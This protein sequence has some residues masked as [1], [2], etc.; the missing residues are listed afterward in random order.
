MSEARLKQTANSVYWIASLNR[1]DITLAYY[2][3]DFEPDFYP[4]GSREYNLAWE[5][6]MKIP[7]IKNVT[8]TSWNKNKVMSNMG[9]DCQ[10]IGPSVDIDL[11]RPR[12]RS[13]FIL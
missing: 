10:I 7:R 4:K 11:F 9:I 3:Q 1:S 2:I 12:E 6:Y 8:K 5:S 13:L